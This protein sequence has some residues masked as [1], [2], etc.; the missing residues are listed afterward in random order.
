M[1]KALVSQQE[2]MAAPVGLG[3]VSGSLEDRHSD[4]KGESGVFL[5]T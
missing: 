4:V 1:W 2:L 5:S 3:C